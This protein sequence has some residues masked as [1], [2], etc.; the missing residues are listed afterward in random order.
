MNLLRLFNHKTA[1]LIGY[2][3]NLNIFRKKI[4]KPDI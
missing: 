1:L 2:F 4:R 3:G